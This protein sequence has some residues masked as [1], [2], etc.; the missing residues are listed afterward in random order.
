M[1]EMVHQFRDR[2]IE[3]TGE[4]DLPLADL[5]ALGDQLRRTGK[6]RGFQNLFEQL[7]GKIP[8]P[9]LRK[10]F[11]AAEKDLVE[12]VSRIKVRYPEKRQFGERSDAFFRGLPQSLLAFRVKRERMHQIGAYQCALEVVKCRGLSVFVHVGSYAMLT[13][14][15][16][17][18]FL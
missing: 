3:C 13:T 10:A 6:Y 7:I 2:E 1:P 12:N 4:H 15:N 8:Q 16:S 14:P 9:I 11:V 5:L 18:K 17:D